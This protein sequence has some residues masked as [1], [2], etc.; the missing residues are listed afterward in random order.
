CI[1]TYNRAAHLANCLRSIISSRASSN[2]AFEVCVSDNCSTDETEE[3][4]NRARQSL[5]IKYKKNP[6]NLGIPRNFL[7]V[8]DMA[9]GEF[10]WLIGD[11][12]LLLPNALAELSGLIAKHPKVDFFYINSFHLTTQYVFS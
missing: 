11:D 2:I 1:P 5:A 8:V 9:D 3:V 7:N 6:T 12:D 4:V 10:V